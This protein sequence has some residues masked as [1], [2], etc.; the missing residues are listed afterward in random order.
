MREPRGTD[1]KADFD[2]LLQEFYRIIEDTADP[3]GTEN[4]RGFMLGPCNLQI[5]VPWLG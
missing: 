3:T 1:S 2:E 5:G 4:V